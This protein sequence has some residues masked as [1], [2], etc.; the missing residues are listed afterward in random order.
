MS[1]LTEVLLLMSL[2]WGMTMFI[3]LLLRSNTLRIVRG[4]DTYIVET[5]LSCSMTRTKL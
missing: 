5:L 4:G 2:L 3:E 1:N